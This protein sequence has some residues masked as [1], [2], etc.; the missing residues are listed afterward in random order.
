MMMNGWKTPQQIMEDYDM[1]TPVFYKYKSMCEASKFSDAVKRPSS[2]ITYIVE[3]RWQEFLNWQSEEWKQKHMDP[4][5][6]Q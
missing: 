5:M 6:R 4:H 2:R 1:S 3:P